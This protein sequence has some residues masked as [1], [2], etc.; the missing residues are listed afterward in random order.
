MLLGIVGEKVYCWS[1]EEQRQE[2]LQES[3]VYMA[4]RLNRA[5]WERE[6]DGRVGTTRGRQ[7]PRGK[8]GLVAKMADVIQES[9]KLGE[10][11]P[12]LPAGE[13]E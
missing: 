7:Q 3:R 11:Q 10:R 5:V 9:E 4:G 1:E 6:R 12:R 13:F 8:K 2:H